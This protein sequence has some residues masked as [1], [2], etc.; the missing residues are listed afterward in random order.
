VV[1]ARGLSPPMPKIGPNVRSLLRKRT[2]LGQGC[3]IVLGRFR[4]FLPPPGG[5]AMWRVWEVARG[6]VVDVLCDFLRPPSQGG[7]D[8]GDR[9]RHESTPSA[10]PSEPN[11]PGSHDTLGNHVCCGWTRSCPSKIAIMIWTSLGGPKRPRASS[12][13]RA[14]PG[15]GGMGSSSQPRRHLVDDTRAGIGK[16]DRRRRPIACMREVLTL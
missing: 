15:R 3:E 2:F 12:P 11:H 16:R 10:R 1:I 8:C 13:Y 14:C 9:H 4:T 5:A 7:F 6:R